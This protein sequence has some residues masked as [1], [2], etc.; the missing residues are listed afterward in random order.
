M[1]LDAGNQQRDGLGLKTANFASRPLG[2][3]GFDIDINRL[4]K[5]FD[6]VFFPLQCLLQGAVR[7]LDGQD[8]LTGS[9]CELI[10]QGIVLCT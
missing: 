3:A 6:I 2:L 5:E 1:G 7:S 9:K 8:Q 10:T 4:I